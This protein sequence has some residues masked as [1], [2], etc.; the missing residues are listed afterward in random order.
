M[1]K[2]SKYDRQHLRNLARYRKQI[3]AI[4]DAALHEAAAIGGLVPSLDEGKL[5]SFDDYPI[6]HDRVRRLLGSLCKELEMCVVNGVRSEWT[7]ANNKNDALC[8]R[9]FGSRKSRL[10]YEAARRYYAT[11]APALEAFLSRQEQGLGLS[12]RVW[13]YTDMFRR[14]IELGLDLGIRSGH[15]ARQ[16]ASSL[17]QYLLHHDK[18]FRRVRDEHGQLTLSRAAADFHPGRGVYRSSYMNA[19]RLTATETN[20]AYRTADHDRWQQ[21]DFVVG[22]DVRCSDTNHTQPDICDT[23]AGRYPKD[24]VFTGWHPFCR[25]YV[26]P[27]LKTEEEVDADMQRILRGED[28]LPP[29]QS[30]NAVEE[31]P[32]NF[33]DWVREN[34][35][36]IAAATD[37]G[38]LPY[39][40]RDNE[41]YI[42]TSLEEHQIHSF[43]SGENVLLTPT[44]EQDVSLIQD[45][46]FQL[47]KDNPSWFRRGYTGIETTSSQTGGYMSTD[48]KGRITINFAKD[49]NGFNAGESV[50][51]AFK[52]LKEGRELTAHEE[53]SIEMLWHEI[54][55]NKTLNTVVLPDI[56]THLGFPRSVA[57]TINQLV[58]R[59]TYPDFLK[60][61]GGKA[62]H[63]SWVL[64]YGISYRE[65]VANIRSIITK[66]RITES[67]FVT[68][69]QKILMEDYS[70][71]DER[72]EKLL[73]NLCSNKRN[74]EN[75]GFI[76]RRIELEDFTEYLKILK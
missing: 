75:I 20:M 9:V 15:D 25:C 69:A 53:Y 22:Q 35:E 64:E 51:S 16:M 1:S 74:K 63:Q 44:H 7:L 8:D 50:L 32:D 47:Q 68:R 33:A 27:V 58:A 42:G 26:V 17:K 55:H 6:T 43:L 76:F 36:R 71:I 28:P 70:Q 13:R 30:E 45:K 12:D 34:E 59:H 56:D 48:S 3:E 24:F 40:I 72:I 60:K 41:K 73:I 23:L 57:E 19:L 18:L 10:P 61:L 37:R 38:T 65:Y 5:F 14:E 2:P 54:L 11:N 39:F 29:S 66:A 31:V 46:L 49:V 67:D 4:Y 62:V 21:L 52:K